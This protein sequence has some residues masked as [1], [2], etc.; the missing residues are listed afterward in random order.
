MAIADQ[1]QAEADHRA[2]DLAARFADGRCIACHTAGGPTGLGVVRFVWHKQVGRGSA[3]GLVGPA[4]AEHVSDLPLCPNCMDA[5]SRRRRW[6]PMVRLVGGVTLALALCG[7]AGSLAVRYL[8]RLNPTE[9]AQNTAFLI[10]S[11]VLLPIALLLWQVR[12]RLSVP[13]PLLVMTGGG[14]E[15]SDAK[16]QPA[17]R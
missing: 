6:W 8:M 7:L 17:G 16:L 10:A 1:L 13:P 2:A 14:W 12:R 9:Q 15:C 5:F 11:A 3:G 4:T